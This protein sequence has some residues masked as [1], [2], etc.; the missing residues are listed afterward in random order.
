MRRVN[1]AGSPQDVCPGHTGR[2]DRQLGLCA[3]RSSLAEHEIIEI[4]RPA[5]ERQLAFVGPSE[6]QHVV[7][8]PLHVDGVFEASLERCR[9]RHARTGLLDLHG[10]AQAGQWRAQLMGG[11]RHESALAGHLAVEALEHVIHRRGELG[12]LVVRV[13]DRDPAVEV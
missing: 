5:S 2:V 9:I 3:S 10:G 11:I 13:G 12:D 4:D 7:H 1:W 8:E 6:I